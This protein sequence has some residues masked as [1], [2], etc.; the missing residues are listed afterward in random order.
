MSIPLCSFLKVK[1]KLIVNVMKTLLHITSKCILSKTNFAMLQIAKSFRNY[2]PL[3]KLA[4]LSSLICIS[5]SMR[6]KEH[7]REGKE[8]RERERER[9]RMVR[10]RQ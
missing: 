4:I 10:E 6:V 7:E 8:N 2:L 3:L 9:K 1:S 5:K